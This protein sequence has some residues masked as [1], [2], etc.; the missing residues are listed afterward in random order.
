MSYFS[1][2]S[3]GDSIFFSTILLILAGYI[4]AISVRGKWKEVGE[5][6]SLFMKNRKNLTV[7]IRLCNVL[8]LIGSISF[9]VASLIL[10]FSFLGVET[11]MYA[12]AYFIL[13]GLL[14]FLFTYGLR[15]I[16]TGNKHLLP[17]K[18]S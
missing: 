14:P 8:H 7:L 11:A 16:L 3:I 6:F 9:S 4:Y 18:E 12:P 1:L 5:I 17:F 13:Y 10:F 2:M 15:Y